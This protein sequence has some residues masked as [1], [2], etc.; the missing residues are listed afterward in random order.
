MQNYHYNTKIGMNKKGLP[1]HRS[2]K[3]NILYHYSEMLNLLSKIIK[4]TRNSYK[5]RKLKEKQNK[6][7]SFLKV[8]LTTNFVLFLQKEQL[9][10]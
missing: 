9:I 7:K 4:S 8:L 3:D 5:T 2:S 1:F 10:H 6:I